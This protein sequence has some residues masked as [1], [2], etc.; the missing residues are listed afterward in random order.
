MKTRP[1]DI[2]HDSICVL[3]I[4]HDGNSSFLKGPAHAPQTIRQGYFSASSNLWT[5]SGM[6]LGSCDVFYDMGDLDFFDT[7]D[8]FQLITTSVRRILENRNHLIC[9]GGDHAITYPV[10]RSYSAVYDT[11]TILHLDAHPDLYDRLD[12]NP[13]SHACPFARILEEFPKTRLIQAGIRTF[14]GHQREQAN[15]FNVEVHEAKDGLSWF[16]TLHINAPV[17]LSIDLDCLDP[18]FAPGV[19]HHEPGGLS[20]REVLHIIQ[21]LN[22][23]IIGA[24]IVEYNPA[25]DL[26][27]VTAMV[28]AKLLKETAARMIQDRQ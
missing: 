26:N 5:E 18:A 3:G 9:L 6:D 27:Q 12:G 11:L 22:G 20:T 23:R 24:D 25:R 8:D 7:D 1:D 15:R 19:S 14:N 13:Y 4:P 2:P 17:Y 21:N 10:I 28:A 16:E